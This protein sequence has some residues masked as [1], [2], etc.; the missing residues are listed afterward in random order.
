MEFAT[1]KWVAFIRP[2]YCVC[3]YGSQNRQSQPGA[4]YTSPEKCSCRVC[5]FLDLRQLYL[6]PVH[7]IYRRSTQYVT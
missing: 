6:R 4:N 3:L 7:S 5:M 2:L 1:E